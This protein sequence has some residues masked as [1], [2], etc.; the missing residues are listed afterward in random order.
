VS[1]GPSSNPIEALTSDLVAPRPSRVGSVMSFLRS[2]P[3]ATV[4]LG[5]IVFFVLIA[6]L[7]PYIAPYGEHE[8]SGR[9]YEAP[10]S[11]H[12]LGT[13]DVGED[14]LTLMMYGAQVSLIVGFAAA[15]VTMIIGGAV[16]IF[17]GYFGGK[18][19]TV[20]MRITDY[21]LVIP[22]IPLMLV[23][24]AIWGRSLTNIIVI[25]GVIYWTTTARLIRAQTASVRERVFVK[26]A[27]A[28]GAGHARIVGRHLLPQVAP[29]LIAITVLSVAFAI[30][31]ETAIAFLGLG[32]PSLTSWGKLIENAFQGSA[33]TLGAYWAIVPPGVA[34]ALVVLACTM[35]GR[36]LED[37]LN[38][39]LRAG[40]LSVRQ[41]RV[42]PRL[43]KETP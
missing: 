41:F 32:D 26:R 34:V 2:N 1:T 38:P 5:I 37:A 36:S 31:A 4:G 19:D 40:H 13:D 30:F 8:R 3:S 23:A 20:L 15:L 17:A 27:H 24:A 14:M 7:A 25:I 10:S 33:I 22:D 16:G 39:R 6:V 21:F 28:I 35:V 42:L 11:A 12:W 9:P 29:L 18:T 43:P